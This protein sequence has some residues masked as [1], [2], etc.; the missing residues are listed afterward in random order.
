MEP[1][2]PSLNHHTTS[3]VAAQRR[4]GP[5]LLGKEKVGQSRTNTSTRDW[6]MEGCRDLHPVDKVSIQG[7]ASPVES[8]STMKTYEGKTTEGCGSGFLHMGCEED[9]R[10]EAGESGQTQAAP[11]T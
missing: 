4:E 10:D 8:T 2:A 1:K 11:L 5:T 6:G 3:P 9:V 7:R